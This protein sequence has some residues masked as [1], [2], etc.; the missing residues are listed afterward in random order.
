MLQFLGTV[1]DLAQAM[2]YAQPRKV[3]DLIERIRGI[4][5]QEQV[6][7]SQLETVVG[8]CRSMSMGVPEAVLYTRTQYA[9]LRRT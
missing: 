6:S 3:N 9:A 8:K 4:I 2:L 1:V 7:V 5:S